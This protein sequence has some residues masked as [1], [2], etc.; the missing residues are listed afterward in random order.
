MTQERFES[1]AARTGDRR[2]ALLDTNIWRYIVDDGA[3]GRFLRIGR[4]ASYDV[5]V[6]PVVVYET[7]RLKDVQLRARIVRLMTNTRFGRLM[8]EAYSESMEILREV[9]RVRPD[10]LRAS[11]DIR[12]FDRLKND[13]SRK[14]GGFWVR[15]A[16]SPATDA[17]YLGTAEGEM[18]EN[19][20]AQA[21]LARDEMRAS[22]WKWNP[23]MDKTLAGFHRPLPGWN[24]EMVEAWRCDRLTS[25]SFALARQGNPYRDWIAPFIELDDGL[26]GSP[27]WNEFWLHLADKRTLP[28]QWMRW[29]HSFAQRFR[30]VTPGS[31]GDTALFTY[32][33]D[34]DVVVTADR[35]LVDILEECRPYAPCQLPE[36]KLLAAGA[37]GIAGLFSFLQV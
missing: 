8:P 15:C 28:R 32:F 18:I 17:G 9:E 31:P 5:Q 6:A 12:F 35:A 14:T 24:G 10:W 11:P 22:D 16:E 19:A 27:D 25:L 3:Q 33:L 34:T 2:R 20:R 26:L 23:P 13:W 7:L 30:K 4:T 1:K 37:S 29:G 21:R 36:G